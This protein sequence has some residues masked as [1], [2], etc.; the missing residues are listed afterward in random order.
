[1]EKKIQLFLLP[2]AGGNAKSFNKLISCLDESIEAISIEYAGRGARRKNNFILE[3]NA[4]LEDVAAFIKDK[5]N[6]NLPYALLG[7]SMGSALV[8]DLIRTNVLDS[9]PQIMVLCARGFLDHQFMSQK[10]AFLGEDEFIEKVKRLGGMDERILQ[11]RRFLD[12]YLEPLKSDYK[13]WSQY[14]YIPLPQNIGND[15]LVFY[16]EADSPKETVEG[17]K[18]IT[19]GTT[20]MYEFGHNHFFINEYYMEM[21]NIINNKIITL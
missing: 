15:I 19:T 11:N 6:T 3:Y 12:I 10:Y 7:Y 2:F 20:E 1:M 14:K 16:S 17:W 13:V 9:S 5:R 4:F 18:D 21:A 8:Y